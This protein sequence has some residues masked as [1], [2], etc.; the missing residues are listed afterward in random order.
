MFLHL[1]T[2]KISSILELNSPSWRDGAEQKI[3]KFIFNNKTQI[4]CNKIVSGVLDY[5][6]QIVHWVPLVDSEIS[7]IIILGSWLIS[8]ISHQLPLD[9]VQVWPCLW[10]MQHAQ[11]DHCEAETFILHWQD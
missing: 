10:I 3:Q 7:P 5:F 2:L 8:T 6:Q 1:Y 11:L 9:R 4:L